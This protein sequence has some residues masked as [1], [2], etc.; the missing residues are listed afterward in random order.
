M[1]RG[2]DVVLTPLARLV[3]FTEYVADRH[4]PVPSQRIVQEL[5]YVW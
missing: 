1:R 2:E 5:M 4:L 3:V